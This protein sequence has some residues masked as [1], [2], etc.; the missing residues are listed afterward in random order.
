MKHSCEVIKDILPLYQENL[1]SEA[2][3]HLVEEHLKHCQECRALLDASNDGIF[4]VQDTKNTD[5]EAVKGLRDIKKS[6]RRK[7]WLISLISIIGSLL[8][9]FVPTFFN[10]YDVRSLS[11][12][13]REEFLA[14]AGG[15]STFP[16]SLNPGAYAFQLYRFQYGTLTSRQEMPMGNALNEKGELALKFESRTTMALN[17][18]QQLES[19]LWSINSGKGALGWFM[20]ED[21]VR[22]DGGGWSSNSISGTLNLGEDEMPI[23]YFY[24]TQ[25]STWPANLDALVFGADFTLEHISEFEDFTDVFIVTIKQIDG[26]FLR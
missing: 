20:P 25:S 22:E 17:V 21:H 10:R 7:I 18:T 26:E 8:T 6:I 16:F 13:E 15:T 5:T 2:T 4:Q 3:V 1:C 12:S 14:N 19:T 11:L 9:L 24:F 23:A